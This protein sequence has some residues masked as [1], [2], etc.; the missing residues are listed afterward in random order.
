MGTGI[1]VVD[2]TLLII[3]DLEVAAR[4][5]TTVYSATSR[6]VKSGGSE[7]CFVVLETSLPIK[8]AVAIATRYW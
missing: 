4:L 6:G 5:G 3:D 8:C 1:P 2:S 7:G